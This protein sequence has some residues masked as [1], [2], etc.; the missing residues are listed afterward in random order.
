M[1]FSG[2]FL[3]FMKNLTKIAVFENTAIQKIFSILCTHTRHYT[4]KHRISSS[5]LI[6]CK[7]E[8]LQGMSTLNPLQ[9]KEIIFLI[10]R[11][12]KSFKELFF[13][14]VFTHFCLQA[15]IRKKEDK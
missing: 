12:P 15:G 13:P 7:W 2:I 4:A 3:C 5:L 11:N 8:S 10:L 9:Q 6:K 1:K 14:K